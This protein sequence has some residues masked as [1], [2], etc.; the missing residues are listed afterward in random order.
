MRIFN[1][2]I[3]RKHGMMIFMNREIREIR[4]RR[5]RRERVLEEVE[6]GIVRELLELRG[7]VG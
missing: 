5:E 2:G 7:M 4:E 1:H 3:H 6:S